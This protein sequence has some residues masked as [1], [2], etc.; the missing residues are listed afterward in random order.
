MIR[1]LALVLAFAA[2]SAQAACLIGCET[3]VTDARAATL[4]Q[5]LTQAAP[6]AGVRVTHALEGGFQD[7]F[8]QLRAEADAPGLAAL[9]K[10]LALTEADLR[11]PEAYQTTITATDWWTPA[12]PGARAAT[13]A[14]PGVAHALLIRA[15]DPARPGVTLL[16]L[17]AFQT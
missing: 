17:L 1:A 4:W 3:E 8:W 11:P 7:P 9:M 14:L 15:A 5:A 13:V 2:P 12:L 10:R 16:F 6:P